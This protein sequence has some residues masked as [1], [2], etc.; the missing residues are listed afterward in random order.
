VKCKNLKKFTTLKKDRKNHKI[1]M[2]SEECRIED[3]MGAPS[4]DGGY[5][6]FEESKQAPLPMLDI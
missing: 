4:F 5:E 6:I 2:P 3:T 1:R